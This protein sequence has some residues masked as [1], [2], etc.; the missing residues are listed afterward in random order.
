MQ[1]PAVNPV[2][3]PRSAAA[4]RVLTGGWPYGRW[5]LWVLAPLLAAL[6]LALHAQRNTDAAQ[7]LA[8]ETAQLQARTALVIKN[9]SQSADIQGTPQGFKDEF[10]AY[11]LRLERL[12]D[13]LARLAQLGPTTSN[14]TPATSYRQ[15]ALGDS[16]LLA[17]QVNLATTT[18]YSAW[19]DFV[20]DVLWVDP[21]LSLTSLS[22][23]RSD[24]NAAQ[25]RVQ[26]VFSFYMQVPERGSKSSPTVPRAPSAPTA[27]PGL[28]T[29]QTGTAP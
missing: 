24:A 29:Q 12:Q 2:A 21:A 14:P 16:G 18:T 6:A 4:S 23:N 8:L 10:P 20:D 26:A 22:L 27:Q 1:S 25:V 3:N 17:Y 15:T 28:Q 13:F 7:A 5:V 11:A 19:R 9:A